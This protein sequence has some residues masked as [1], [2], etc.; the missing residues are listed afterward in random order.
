MQ[1]LGI[2]VQDLRLGDDDAA[3]MDDETLSFAVQ[4]FSSLAHPTRLKI[5]EL[6]TEGPRTVNDVAQTLRILQPN[7][8]QHLAV[9][10]RC[11]VVKMTPDGVAR[12]YA[13]RG[14]R[15]ARILILVNEFRHVH[16]TA[17][18]EDA[19]ASPDLGEVVDKN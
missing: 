19:V 13:L 12:L 14:P 15:I 10:F 8:S 2:K 4:L 17:L 7:A 5:V 18:A 6:L 1:D 16:A 11:G 3:S 9:L